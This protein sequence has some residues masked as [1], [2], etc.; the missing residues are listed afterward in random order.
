MNIQLSNGDTIT[1]EGNETPDEIAMLK[2]KIAEFES[3]DDGMSFSEQ[4]GGGLRKLVGGATM[5]FGDE[6]TSM[7]GA[8]GAYPVTGEPIMQ[9]YNRGLEQER[10]S[11][12]RMGEENPILSTILEVGGGVA[13]ATGL[14]KGLM[15]GGAKLAPQITRKAADIAGKNI[16]T[17]AATAAAIGAGSGGFYGFGTGTGGFEE[18][19]GEATEAGKFGAATGLGGAAFA[20]VLSKANIA[21]KPYTKPITDK[22]GQTAN[23]IAEKLNIVKQQQSIVPM[24][25]GQV[26]QDVNVQQF[27]DMA[28]K[29]SL[30]D[31]AKDIISRFDERQQDELLSFVDRISKGSD[32]VTELNNASN[33]VRKAYKDLK[34]K[35]N[36]AYKD[37]EVLDKTYIHKQPLTESLVP[38]MRQQAKEFGESSIRDLDSA[39]QGAYKD[40]TSG[41][42][43]KD[44]KISTVKLS[45]LEDMRKRLG[46]AVRSNTDAFGNQNPSGVF[47]LKMKRALDATLEEMPKSAFKSG[48]T[49]ALEKIY[50]AR[51]LRA[52]KG[53]KFD[54]NK[55]ISN[56]VK[57]DNLNNEQLA[58]IVLT[59]SQAGK[60]IG[61]NTVNVIRA[62]KVASGENA[63]EMI[64]S[65]KRGL[66]A[67][68]LKNSYGTTLR[69][70]VNQVRVEPFK[71]RNELKKIIDN[72]SL[73]NE[74]FDEA[75]QS[76]IKQ[77]YDDLLRISSVQKG[78]ENYSNSAIF[79]KRY[80]DMIPGVSQ[81]L[82]KPLQAISDATAA[83]SIELATKQFSDELQRALAGNQRFYGAVGSAP[84]SGMLG[85]YG[86]ETQQDIDKL[87][88]EYFMRDAQGNEYFIEEQ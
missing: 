47:A 72:K 48:D 14:A 62:M 85:E 63:P 58:N 38:A 2:H 33:S 87:R 26:T 18:R 8:V 39:V 54:S 66:F 21:I 65:I 77:G 73:M 57:N 49:S 23:S 42:L 64:D 59:G 5:G 3:V 60:N 51:S 83:E 76:Y 82:S 61:T 74:L 56:I 10:E 19:V 9:A 13:G 20:P 52:E 81:L 53:R 34:T 17:K 12:S 22:V 29:G 28:R 24:T 70:G 86:Y 68:V 32:E 6:I 31:E 15:K 27:E 41:F 1:L 55:V 43:V 71:L 75:E 69:E 25:K 79:L 78:G 88:Q 30:G 45:A 67:K 16:G 80:A 50:K 44:K 84:I 35:I 7:V 40:L 36:N 46:N 4:I 11:L 37:A